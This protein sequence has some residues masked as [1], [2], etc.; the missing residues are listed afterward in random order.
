[1]K[2]LH[3]RENRHQVLYNHKQLITKVKV[4]LYNVHN[5]RRDGAGMQATAVQAHTSC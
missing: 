4:L 1:V 3:I 2:F 5:H